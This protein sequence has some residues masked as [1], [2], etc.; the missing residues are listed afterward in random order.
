MGRIPGNKLSD[1]EMN[2][3]TPIQ[4]KEGK[5]NGKLIFHKTADGKWAIDKGEK[6]LI[7]PGD[8]VTIPAGE[9]HCHGAIEDSAFSH[10]YVSRLG[11]RITQL[12]E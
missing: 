4:R 5:M 10:I 6:K 8:I 3:K 11:G 7:I 2:G 9:K 12:E 1:S